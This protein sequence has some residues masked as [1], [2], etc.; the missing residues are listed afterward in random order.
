MAARTRVAVHSAMDEAP[1]A[2]DLAEAG[3]DPAERQE[4]R[5]RPL[6]T[7][8]PPTEVVAPKS[9]WQQRGLVGEKTSCK[10]GIGDAE[11]QDL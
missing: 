5:R 8:P 9:P 10:L 1:Q 3:A 7:P 6:A 11:I 4:V 2:G